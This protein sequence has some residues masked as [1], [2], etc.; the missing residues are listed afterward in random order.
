MDKNYTMF[1]QLK[2]GN[3]FMVLELSYGRRSSILT[4]DLY[5]CHAIGQDFIYI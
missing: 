2:I 1:F 4:I 3:D 5:M